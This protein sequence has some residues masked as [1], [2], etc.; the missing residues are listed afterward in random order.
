MFDKKGRPRLSGLARLFRCYHATQWVM[1]AQFVTLLPGDI[2]SETK[3]GAPSSV[4]A[5]ISDAR[6][7]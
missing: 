1:K 4:L 5:P 2:Q 6:S 3:E 7:P